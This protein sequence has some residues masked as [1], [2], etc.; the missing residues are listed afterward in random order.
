MIKRFCSGL[1]GGFGLMVVAE[2]VTDDDGEGFWG[3][4][5]C[6]VENFGLSV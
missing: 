3:C 4:H 6:Y 1:E 2:E 5:F